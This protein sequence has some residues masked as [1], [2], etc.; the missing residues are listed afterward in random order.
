MQALRRIRLTRDSVLL[1]LL[2]VLIGGFSVFVAWRNNQIEEGRQVFTPFSTHSSNERGALGLYQWLEQ[3]GYRTTRIEN[4]DFEI[5]D[6]TRMLFVLGPT[7]TISRNEASYILNWVERGNTLIF[8]EDS[9]FSKNELF[10]AL[11]VSASFESRRNAAQLSQPLADAEIGELS[12]DTAS[13]LEFNTP[14]FVVYATG[15]DKPILA[16]M[17][18]GGG[19]IWLTTAPQLFTNENLRDEDNAGFAA[20]LIADLPKGSEIAFDEYHLGFKADDETSLSAVIFNTPW[21]WGLIF[22]MLVIFGYLA[23][24]GQRFGRILPV[25]RAL[26]RRS[27]SEYVTS[28]ANL[29]R[30]ADKRGMVLQHYRHSLKR[31]LG[32]PFHLNPELED[33]RYVEMLERLRPELDR[34]ELARLLNSL[35]QTDTTEADLVRTIEQAVNFGVRGP[36]STNR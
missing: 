1:V 36:G 2:L 4:G 35:R 30:R 21:G 33:S 32:R 9:V 6:K 11:D 13:A 5:G 10:S 8:A 22:A 24:N 27:P 29:F 17:Q 14:E 12:A 34:A 19:T 7:E 31:R 25:P 20:A 16:R 18:R 3:I 26:A 15:K 23:L 28:M